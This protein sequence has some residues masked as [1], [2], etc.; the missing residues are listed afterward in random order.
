MAQAFKPLPDKERR[1]L[2]D[3]LSSKNKQALDRYFREHVDA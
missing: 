2:S 3:A 1:Q